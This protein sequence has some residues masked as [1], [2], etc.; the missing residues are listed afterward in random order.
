MAKKITEIRYLSH[1]RNAEHYHL[2]EQLVAV[3]PAEF[4]T[5]Y[6]IGGFR[7]NYVG[8]FAKEDELYLQGLAYADTKVVEAKDAFRDQRTRHVFLKVEDGLLSLV[9]EEVEAAK[10]LDFMMAPYRNASSKPF[11]ENSALISDLVKKLQS[12]E[13]AP[14]VEK[15][16]MTAIVAALKTANDDFEAVYSRRADLKLVRETSDKLKAIR[17]QVNEAFRL[18][19]E[20]I[21]A[22]YIVA[23]SIEHDA[24]KAAEVGTVIDAA[25]AQILQFSQTLSRRGVG[26]KAK[27]D[28]E[29]PPDLNPGG[30][31]GEEERPGEL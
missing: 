22:L 23:E 6:K 30:G 7:D 25:N 19:A 8:L 10:K 9:E 11:A 26:G 12:S 4:A 28:P 5:K 31:G 2:H 27:L 13:Y 1:A 20:A 14:L 21:S 18:L 3:I 29:T 24:A 15:L 17:R 16:G